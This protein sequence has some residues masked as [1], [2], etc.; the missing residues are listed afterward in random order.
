[1]SD[2]KSKAIRVELGSNRTPS[3]KDKAK[4]IDGAPSELESLARGAAQGATLG[5]ADELT[6]AL[7]TGYDTLTGQADIM[8]L[9]AEYQRNRDESR[10]AYQDAETTNPMSYMSGNVAGGV[11]TAFIPGLNVAKGTT[12]VASAGKA[13]L[14]GG[15]AGFGTSDADLT[16]GEYGQA[17]L[18]IAQGS[19]L[20]GLM[21]AAG[22]GGAKLIDKGIQK[23]QDIKL[24]DKAFDALKGTAR[25][26]ARMSKDQADAFV[27]DPKGV[28]SIA[29]MLED[30]SRLP[31]LQDQ[32][33]KAIETTRRT[34][35]AKG[36]G[37]ASELREALSDKTVKVNPKE[38]Y[39]IDPEIDEIVRYFE[40]RKV[41]TP[42]Q[43]VTK[44][45][46]LDE[47]LDLVE[48]PANEANQ[49]KRILRDKAK[50]RAGTITDPVQ[51][52][53]KEGFARKASR[54]RGSI[55]EAGGDFVKAMNKEM[56][57]TILVQEG[58]R[59]G[60]KNS[61]I[62]FTSTQSPDRLA[63]IARAEKAGAKG[64]I[65]F[66]NKL[67]AAKSIASNDVDDALSRQAQKFAGRTA[68]IGIDKL[69]QLV[70]R[71][72]QS[73]G[74]YAS[75][76]TNAAQRGNHAVAATHFILSQQDPEYRKKMRE[77]LDEENE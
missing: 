5:F 65:D 52:A 13:A 22:H 20:G 60:Q 68:L 11:A 28:Q 38:L 45:Y 35:K 76:L 2:W 69:N 58:L 48:L 16:E 23:A 75:T 32:A 55:E 8:D 1:M 10:A 34:L 27:L 36:L 54:L 9:A 7:E 3:W 74:R 66:G 12:L 26:A 63:T 62:A 56:Q 51:D 24:G 57:E 47:S 21:G 77:I 64:I 6:G 49:I 33:A 61:P 46:G 31:E 37:K 25:R 67:G 4:R 17:A 72:P 41:Y 40:S 70:S 53:L 30:S 50:Y 43:H 44:G 59:K 42:E 15:I 71:A 18:D 29:E 14:A 73:F 19:A 39:G